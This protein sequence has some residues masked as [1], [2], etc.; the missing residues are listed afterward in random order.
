MV[1]MNPNLVKVYQNIV[2]KQPKAE[3]IFEEALVKHQVRY[4][5]QYP[6]GGGVYI[7]D[8]FIIDLRLVVEIDDPS[9]EKP[10]RQKRDALKNAYLAKQGY[11]VVRVTNAQ[12]LADAPGVVARIL[13]TA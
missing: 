4:R 8:F 3:R 9:H 11:R 12:V 13:G 1:A 10:E 7:L 5:T 2:R 6:M